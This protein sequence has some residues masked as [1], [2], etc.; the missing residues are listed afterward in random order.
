MHMAFPPQRNQNT[1][2]DAVTRKQK[3]TGKYQKGDVR[4]CLTSSSSYAH[5]QRLFG[6]LGTEGLGGVDHVAERR[7]GLLPLAGLQA[8]VGVNPELL[9]LEELEHLRD[10][11]LDLLL[12][13]D[14]R[15]VDVVDT[16]AN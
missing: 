16:G 3:K 1:I 15:R 4:L 2:I 6:V 10:A 7:N 11:V 14:T 5:W 9:G 12:G 13:G 8:A